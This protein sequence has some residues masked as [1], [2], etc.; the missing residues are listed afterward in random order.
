MDGA[1]LPEEVGGGAVR[2]W[3][4]WRILRANRSVNRSAGV[5]EEGL[6]LREALVERLRDQLHEILSVGRQCDGPGLPP[7]LAR[8]GLKI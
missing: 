8:N 3:I 5:A 7:F 1:V 4:T 2:G 6:R